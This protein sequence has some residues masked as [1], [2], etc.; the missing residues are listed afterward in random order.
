LAKIKGGHKM[1]RKQKKSIYCR[2]QSFSFT[3]SLNY[4]DF[5]ADDFKKLRE[6]LGRQGV[7]VYH[8]EADD[9]GKKFTIYVDINPTEK[10]AQKLKKV[11]QKNKVNDFVLANLDKYIIIPKEIY[12]KQMGLNLI[13]L[14][15]DAKAS[16]DL[17][18]WQEL[19]E[20]DSELEA[21]KG[22]FIIFLNMLPQDEGLFERLFNDFKI[23]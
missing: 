14:L 17:Y 5:S 8:Y 3:I 9:R 10:E 19:G 21:E 2:N 16:F 4:A 23:A 22:D 7:T 12:E 1:P 6:L 20:A 15:D 13:K 18:D 11:L